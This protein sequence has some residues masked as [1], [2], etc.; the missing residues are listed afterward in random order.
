MKK[1]F[2]FLGIVAVSAAAGGATAWTMASHGDA[3][4]LYVD[5]EVERTPGLGTHFTS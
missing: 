5:R 2:L 1:V 3:E 4:V